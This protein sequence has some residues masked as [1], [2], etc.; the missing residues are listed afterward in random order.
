MEQPSGYGIPK[1][2]A[3]EEKLRELG[4]LCAVMS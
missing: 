3:G 2:H 4:S 1:E